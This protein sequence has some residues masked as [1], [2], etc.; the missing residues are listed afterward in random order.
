MS[1]IRNPFFKEKHQEIRDRIRYFAESEIKLKARKLDEDGRFSVELTKKMGEMGLFGIFLPEKYGGKNLDT[2]S[3]II[4]VEELARVDSSQAATVAAHNSL[5]IG[6]IFDYGTEQQKGHFLPLLTTGEKLWAFGLTETTA[7]S[8][9]TNV[10]TNAKLENGKW[11]INGEKIFITNSASELAFG[12]SLLLETGE[13]GGKKEL[14]T[15]LVERSTKGYTTGKILNKIM[16]RSADTGKLQFDKCIVPEENILGKRGQGANIMLKTLDAGRLSLAAIGIGLSQGAY[17]M[18]LSYAKT[19]NQFGQPISKFQAISFKLADMDMKI[20]L[21]RNTLYK[22]CWLKDQ[23]LP[24]SREAAIAKLFSSEIAKDIA[25]DAVQVHGAYGLM[26]DYDIERFYRDQR[27]LQIG[28]G[29]SEILR[30]VI[31]RKIGL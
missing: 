29:T 26:K 14:T 1:I 31:S 16:W 10:K 25:D 12:I 2:L 17:E 9:A 23:G 20:E 7:G 18:A 21:A 3:Y 15:I 5:G 19:R 30:M 22:A 13:T 6:P 4:A 27:I 11:I 28:E 8:D 24:Y